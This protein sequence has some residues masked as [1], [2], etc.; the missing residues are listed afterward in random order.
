MPILPTAFPMYGLEIKTPLP[1]ESEAKIVPL[2]E[3]LALATWS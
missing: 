3:V 2:D 1:P